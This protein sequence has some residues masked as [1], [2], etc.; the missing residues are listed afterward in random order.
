LVVCP[1]R[2]ASAQENTRTNIRIINAIGAGASVLARVRIAL[3]CVGGAVG[4][5]PPFF[6]RKAPATRR[7]PRNGSVDAVESAVG[8]VL[9]RIVGF[10]ALLCMIACCIFVPSTRAVTF[11]S[12]N[13]NLGVNVGA[14]V[15]RSSHARVSIAL[16]DVSGAVIVCPPGGA[17]AAARVYHSVGLPPVGAVE[18]AV[19]SRD[20]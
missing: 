5:F 14:V 16:V 1:P 20:F 8:A 19:A 7:K 6:A 17:I 3:V 11:E 2:G 18:S 15:T 4:A 10:F 9:G 13:F 12:A